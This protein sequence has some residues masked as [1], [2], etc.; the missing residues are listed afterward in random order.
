MSRYASTDDCHANKNT[1]GMTLWDGVT[2]TATRHCDAWNGAC[3]GDCQI[4]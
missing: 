2:W 4:V 1:P 3:D